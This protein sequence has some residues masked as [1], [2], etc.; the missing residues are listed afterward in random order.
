MK[1]YKYIIENI[2]KISADDIILTLELKNGKYIL[3]RDNND[4]LLK[5]RDSD[6][7]WNYLYKHVY[8]NPNNML[9]VVNKVGKISFVAQKGILK[10]R[11]YD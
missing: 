4:V 10:R 11:K 9:K 2:N 6:D 3:S 1:F 5:S 7:I 8:H